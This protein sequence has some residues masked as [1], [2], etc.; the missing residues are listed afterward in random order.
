MLGEKIV[1]FFLPGS[2]SAFNEK[3]IFIFQTFE[4]EPLGRETMG[5]K[6]YGY[7]FHFPE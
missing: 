5:R 6:H 7:D 3:E 4:K 1:I 2:H